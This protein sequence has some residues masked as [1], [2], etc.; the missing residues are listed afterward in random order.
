ML[1][2]IH[3]KILVSIVHLEVALLPQPQIAQVPKEIIQLV[4]RWKKFKRAGDR[5]PKNSMLETYADVKI[6]IPTLVI[7]SARL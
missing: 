1:I 2:L 5:K 4:H 3:A 6:L 7:Y